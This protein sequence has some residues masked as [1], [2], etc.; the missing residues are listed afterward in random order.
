MT[1]RFLL[2]FAFLFAS[3]MAEDGA[4]EL[5]LPPCRYMTPETLPKYHTDDTCDRVAHNSLE[6][7]MLRA[8][9][10]EALL[11]TGISHIPDQL[12][13]TCPEQPVH[14]APAFG[15]DTKWIVENKSSGDAV[16]LF[17]SNGVE[18]SAFDQ[19]ITPPQADPNA[20]L[21][22]G[23]WMAVDTFEGHV[24]HVREV[25]PD[26]STG[27]I[28]LQ[29]RPGLIGFTDRFQKELDCSDYEDIE[30]IV[31][32]Y[33]K[34]PPKEK[35]KLEPIIKTHPDFDRSPEHRGERCN[36]VYQGFRNLLPNCP[37]NIY[38]VGMQEATDGP[39]QC[40]EEFKFHLGL[41]DNTPNYMYD[42]DSRSKFEATF[43]GHTFSARLAT[44]PD[45][46]VDSFTLQPTE[47][48]DCPGLN[49]KQIAQQYVIEPNGVQIGIQ[50]KLNATSME[51]P[52]NVTSHNVGMKAA[53]E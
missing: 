2:A 13:I 52:L 49:Q 24:F 20:V 31:E 44:N 22:P 5:A 17:V 16:V 10:H 35:I 41:K 4:Q 6:K 7:R 11:E 39:M 1:M 25:L 19:S 15:H 42:W 12:T 33:P 48:H 18:Y 51:D 32:V 46:V 27:N 45:I 9:R 50:D 47:I 23:E 8:S 30:P 40:K 14:L 36:I 29:H 3:C 37:L 26:G 53:S 38:Y 43:I 34:P 28:L 21:K